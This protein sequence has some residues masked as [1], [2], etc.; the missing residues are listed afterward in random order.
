MYTKGNQSGYANKVPVG[1]CRLPGIR[2]LNSLV[3][4]ATSPLS[5]NPKVYTVSYTTSQDFNSKLT[6]LSLLTK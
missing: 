5:F 1:S 6:A 2:A 3:D 4:P